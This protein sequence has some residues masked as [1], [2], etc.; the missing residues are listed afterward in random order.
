MALVPLLTPRQPASSGTLGAVRFLCSTYVWGTSN[1]DPQTEKHGRAF[2]GG[3]DKSDEPPY[4]SE[5]DDQRRDFDAVR[6]DQ[7][8]G[9][10]EHVGCA[11]LR[12]LPVVVITVAATLS[13]AR[14]IPHRHCRR[15]P[16]IWL[17][18]RPTTL[19]TNP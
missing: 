3:T 8:T 18:A 16:A 10:M 9:T 14:L 11:R 5:P 1:R 19:S 15:P 7:I 4:K 13:A 2:Q 17:H 6:R 12:A